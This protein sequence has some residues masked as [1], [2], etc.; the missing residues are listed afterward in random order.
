VSRG[1]GSGASVR[2]VRPESCVAA[3]ESSV[4]NGAEVPARFYDRAHLRPGHRID[5]PAVIEAP[6]TT[7]YLPGGF[8]SEIDSL[9]NLI[10]KLK[11][12]S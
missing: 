9:G 2:I 12:A 6:D 5:G 10:G 7:I 8:T 3:V 1:A 11:D 4:E